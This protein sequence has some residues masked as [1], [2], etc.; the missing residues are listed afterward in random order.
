MS[1]WRD[2]F[3]LC[4]LPNVFTAM[5]D[6]LAGALIVGA[7]WRQTG[8]IL[9]VMLASAC[10][11]TGG[12]VLN[13]WRDFKEDLAERPA[14]P[15]PSERIRRIH[16]LLLAVGLFGL[17]ALLGAIPGPAV[18]R[19][20]GLLIATIVLYDVILKEV[21]IAPAV[22]GVCRSL[23]LLL[24]MALVPA[25]DSPIDLSMRIH[26]LVAMGLYI[27]GVTVFARRE[28]L[29]KQGKRLASGGAV[30]WIAVLAVGSL[31]FFFPQEALHSE[32]L[33]WVGIL[34]L[35]TAYRMIQAMLTPRPE[36]IQL[37][38]KTA[39]LGV[40]LLDAGMVAFARGLPASLPVAILLI[41]AIWLGK[42]LYS[43]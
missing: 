34:M 37:A 9:A 18:A 11:Y 8:A 17:G 43:T 23:N 14:R 26:L 20:A 29:P 36:N 40:I 33:A 24:G 10:L 13:D 22:M 32:A 19:I 4:R 35:V 27:T 7:G 42:R 30:T 3:E 31:Q 6:P 25:A 15:L 28:A 39:V 2:W 41:P 12:V 5:A 38:V 1:R 16:A 21:P